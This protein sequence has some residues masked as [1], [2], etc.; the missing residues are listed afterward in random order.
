MIN[1]D[2]ITREY[3]KEQN[4]NWPQILN[5]HYRILIM[6]SSESEKAKALF[7]QMNQM[8]WMIFTKILRNT[9]QI[10]NVKR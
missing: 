6:S 10:K 5:Q 9:I 3:I 2:E 8:I 4:P 1:F 7:Y